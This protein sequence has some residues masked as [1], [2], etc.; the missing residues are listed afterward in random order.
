MKKSKDKAPHEIRVR[1]E[2]GK[3][4]DCAELERRK[5]NRR[6]GL[7]PYWEKN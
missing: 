3:K 7:E 6:G 5:L 2:E 4:R 1:C